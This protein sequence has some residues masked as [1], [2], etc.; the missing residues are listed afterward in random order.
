MLT[1]SRSLGLVLSKVISDTEETGG[2]VEFLIAGQRPATA[3][4]NCG[5]TVHGWSTR[6]RFLNHRRL[7]RLLYAL[8]WEFRGRRRPERW[9]S[10]VENIMRMNDQRLDEWGMEGGGKIAVEKRT[11]GKLCYPRFLNNFGTLPLYVKCLPSLASSVERCFVYCGRSG[12]T[13]RKFRL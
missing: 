13:R 1:S 11:G 6:H 3:S 12:K 8:R 5:R 2:R 4:G 9:R 10:V 7:G